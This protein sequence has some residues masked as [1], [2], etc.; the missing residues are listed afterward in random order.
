MSLP[1]MLDD[2]PTDCDVGIE[3]FFG[4]IV[5]LDLRAPMSVRGSAPS[6]VS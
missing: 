6:G 2:L 5:V 3:H 4:P 1:E